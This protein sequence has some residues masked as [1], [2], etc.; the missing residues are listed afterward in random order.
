MNNIHFTYTDD[1]FLNS[2]KQKYQPLLDTIKQLYNK[3]SFPDKLK[4]NIDNTSLYKNNILS[5][6]YINDELVIGKP[7]YHRIFGYWLNTRVTH[8]NKIR[9]VSHCMIIRILQWDKIDTDRQYD[10][11]TKKVLWEHSQS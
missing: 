3:D 1:S 10:D 8:N 7:T 2:Y 5:V 9:H 11:K 4:S 6:E